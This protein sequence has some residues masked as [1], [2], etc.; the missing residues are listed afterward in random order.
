MPLL[1]HRY[2]S[3][4]RYPNAPWFPEWLSDWF[5]FRRSGYRTCASDC[6]LKNP[7]SAVAP[8]FPFQP[9]SLHP[10]VISY[11]PF[12]CTIY[13]HRVMKILPPCSR[14]QNWNIHLS[15]EI[16]LEPFLILTFLKQRFPHLWQHRNYTI[17]SVRFGRCK[18]EPPTIV[19]TETVNNIMVDE[20]LI[21]LK[22]TIIPSKTNRFTNPTSRSKQK[23]KQW[24]PV[25]INRRGWNKLNKCCL[26]CLCQCM[27][28]W[29]LPTMAFLDITLKPVWWI[30][31]NIPSLTASV[32]VG[33][34]NEWIISSC[35]V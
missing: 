20:N 32:N 29:L 13:S 25:A 19:V 2:S 31:A 22:I 8:V 35:S 24:H 23:C 28:L 30:T 15:S 16:Q 34:S 4:S 12:H 33:C 11:N 10:I 17:A 9:V 21:I 7:E 18:T 27:P 14:K 6:E 3:W 1:P 26:F 5:H